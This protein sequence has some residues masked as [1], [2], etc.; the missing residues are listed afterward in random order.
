MRKL[1][2]AILGL[3]VS[4]SFVMGPR[5]LAF[6]GD[7]VNNGGGLGEKNIILAYQKL[8]RYLDSC[9]N[10]NACNIKDSEKNL[11][12]KI[13]QDLPREYEN[14]KQLVFKSGKKNP[15]IFTIDGEI[16]VAVTGNNVGSN[17]FVN[18]DLLNFKL[19]DGTNQALDLG[20][21]IS[22]L[23]HEMGHHHGVHDHAKLDAL[24]GKVALL[25]LNYFDKAPLLPFSKSVMVHVHNEKRIKAF[26]QSLLYIG[27]EVFDISNAV[28]RIVKCST[29]RIPIILDGMDDIEL[30]T[31][32][33][34]GFHLFNLHWK[35]YKSKKSEEKFL[36]EG[37]V[38]KFCS[39]DST[40]KKF[41]RKHKLE[42]EIVLSKMRQDAK[43]L[44]LKGEG[45][46]VTV[47][48]NHKAFKS[49]EIKI[50]QRSDNWWKIIKFP[51]FF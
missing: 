8:G 46:S 1:K 17:I 38:A 27:E 48:L 26:P 16:K 51:F 24:G 32:K 43:G 40:L 30:A 42:I 12:Q 23:V 18:I 39:N 10:S 15:E 9:I 50:K 29:L 19:D 3:F 6:M 31:R 5:A 35:K 13:A 4:T 11:L 28:R 37:N 20:Q 7:E 14:K 25:N 2:L 33:P 44:S 22:I 21:A 47:P 49:A 36:L 41:E 45:G 34:L